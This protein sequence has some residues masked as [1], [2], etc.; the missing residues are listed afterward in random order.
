MS[1]AMWSGSIS[2]GLVN[3][4]VKLHTA[5]RNREV[6]F[7]LLTKDGTCRLR[8]KL[9][10]PDDDKEK[11]YDYKDTTRGYELG[12][13]QYV[14]IKDEELSALWPEARRTID[15]QDFVGLS[16]ID[17]I[18]YEKAYYLMPDQNGTKAYR[19]LFEAMSRTKK[20]GIATFVMRHKG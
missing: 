8:R 18:Y 15:I 14:V 9:V 11:E 5:V 6:H 19:L 3:I 12:P 20:V 1:R 7:H 2:F 10:C 4:P 16:D 13:D 17:P